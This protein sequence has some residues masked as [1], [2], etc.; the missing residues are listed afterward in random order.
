MVGRPHLSKSCLLFG[1]F[2]LLL[3]LVIHEISEY[4]FGETSYLEELFTFREVQGAAQ[5][6]Y[7]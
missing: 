2:G 1:R 4:P 7:T 6:G 3:R 5:V